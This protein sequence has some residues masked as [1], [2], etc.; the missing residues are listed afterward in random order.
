M[1]AHM[2]WKPRRQLNAVDLEFQEVV[3]DK[4]IPWKKS[5][6]LG[7]VFFL[8][9][10]LKKN[11]NFVQGHLKTHFT[12][13]SIF[14]SSSLRPLGTYFVTQKARVSFKHLW[15]SKSSCGVRWIFWPRSTG[16]GKLQRR[17]LA[18]VVLEYCRCGWLEICGEHLWG[19]C[20]TCPKFWVGEKNNR[21]VELGFSAEKGDQWEDL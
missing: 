13:N 10:E 5:K 4:Q 16:L 17:D 19:F 15:W 12:G 1:L 7:D 2:Q 8:F 18:E 6:F 9:L 14:F 3:V 21:N 20:A 11:A